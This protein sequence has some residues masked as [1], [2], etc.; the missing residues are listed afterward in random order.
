MPLF[1]FSARFSGLYIREKSVN[2]S[3]W[4]T[5]V[6]RDYARSCDIVAWGISYIKRVQP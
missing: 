1:G 6:S 2:A 3:D 5:Q 4:S